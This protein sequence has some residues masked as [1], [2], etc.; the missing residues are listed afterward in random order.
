[1]NTNDF[2]ATL[3]SDNTENPLFAALR[4]LT[5]VGDAQAAFGGDTAMAPWTAWYGT[6]NQE[7]V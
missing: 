6:A 1:M 2:Y 5:Q 4:D 7:L 3:V